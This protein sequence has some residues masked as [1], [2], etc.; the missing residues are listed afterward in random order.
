MRLETVLEFSQIPDS[1]FARFLIELIVWRP[2]ENLFH[3][4]VTIRNWKLFVNCMG[5]LLRADF[6][7]LLSLRIQ[8]G[9]LSPDVESKS[10]TN[11]KSENAEDKEKKEKS[12]KKKEKVSP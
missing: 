1:S 5:L 11:S 3:Q 2:R 10:N 12:K 9:L 8:A 4:I 6:D 7:R